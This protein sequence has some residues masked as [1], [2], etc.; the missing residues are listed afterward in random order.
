MIFLLTGLEFE[1]A[2]IEDLQNCNRVNT[3]NSSCIF[4]KEG[5]YL[6]SGDR[7]CTQIEN[8]YQSSFGVCQKCREQ[9]YLDK[10]EK[11]C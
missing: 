4:C 10:T 1:W 8:C 7:K 9:Y 5:F 2:N 11:K 6:N 3:V